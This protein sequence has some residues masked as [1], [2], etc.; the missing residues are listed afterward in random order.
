MLIYLQRPGDGG[1]VIFLSSDEE[2]CTIPRDILRV[3]QPA[4]PRTGSAYKGKAHSNGSSLPEITSNGN[5]K[6][7]SSSMR[8]RFIL[9]VTLAHETLHMVA[10]ISNI[11]NLIDRQFLVC[12]GSKKIT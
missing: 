5:A 9:V 1:G 8:V 12:A 7:K 10:I 6:S 4:R 11:W 3:V 2:G